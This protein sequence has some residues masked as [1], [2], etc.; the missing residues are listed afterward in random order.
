MD[1]SLYLEKEK[2]SVL[3]WKFSLPAILGMV[4]NAL[5]N[6]I[7]SIFVG[8]GVGEI[9]LTAVSISFPIMIILMAFGMLIGVGAAATVSL[10]LGEKNKAEA[11]LVLGNAV[12]LVLISAVVLT[13]LFLIKLD[14]ILIFLGAEEAVLPLCKEFT[15]IILFGSVFMFVGFGLNNIIRAQGDPKTAMAT[16]LI[17]AIL[18][19]IL[20]PIFIMWMGLGI[21]GSALATVV[22]QAVSAIWVTAYLFGSNSLL[23]IKLPYLRLKK[24]IIYDITRIGASPFLMQ[25]GASAV[26]IIYNYS[27]LEY[28]GD[29]AVAAIGI[30]NRIALLILMPVFGLSQG[31]QPIIGYNYGAKRY[32]RV[33]EALNKAIIA[34]SIFTTLGFLVVEM[35]P[36]QIMR[37]FNDSPELISV[38]ARGL[39]IQLAMLSIIGFQVISANYF[40]AVG[41]ALRA[42]LLSMSRQVIVLIPAIIILPRFWGLY[43][44][45]VAGPL[46]DVIASILTACFLYHELKKLKVLTE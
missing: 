1:N 29:I 15:T 26:T 35:F 31:V 21:K 32:D 12:A 46:S 8:N 42:I 33:Q 37:I 36:E 28:G 3:I 44:V 7:D 2:I 30:I 11:E 38:G 22:A 6:V 25:L 16:M 43:G 40:Q 19:A 13:V 45:W 34:A 17:S 23:K 4:V 14:E 9:G 27:L 39:R 10:R 5:Y 18:N 20:N 41:K 24:R